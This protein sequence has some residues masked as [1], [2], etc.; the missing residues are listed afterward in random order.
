MGEIN[1]SYVTTVDGVDFYTDGFKHS[2]ILVWFE[3]RLLREAGDVAGAI[4]GFCRWASDRV[5]LVPNTRISS[6]GG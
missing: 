2:T 6:I 5:D 1:G 3:G 4:W